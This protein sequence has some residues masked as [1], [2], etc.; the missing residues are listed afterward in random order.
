MKKFIF[1]LFLATVCAIYL[2]TNVKQAVAPISNAVHDIV[3]PGPVEILPDP[4][5]IILEVKQL[6]R[7]ET[8]SISLEKIIYSQKDQKRL[9]GAFKEQLLFVAYGQAIAGV[10]LSYIGV[11]DV[12][13]ININTAKV[14]LPQS[15]I[16]N[17]ILDNQRSYVA[18]RTKG[19][20]ANADPQLETQVRVKAQQVLEESAYASDILETANKNAQNTLK[21]FLQKFGLKNI[22][23]F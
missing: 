21:I 12:K 6:S 20:L 18:L 23:F 15:E 1:T 4:I 2:L 10:D 9:W 13:I 11:G 3:V 19:V 5:T 14:H 8:A 7:L 22:E 17:V 16:F